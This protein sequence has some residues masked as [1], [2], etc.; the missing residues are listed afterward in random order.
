MYPEFFEIILFV[1]SQENAIYLQKMP[2]FTEGPKV[3]KHSKMCKNYNI[4]L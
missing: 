3:K 1:A 2:K 4:D